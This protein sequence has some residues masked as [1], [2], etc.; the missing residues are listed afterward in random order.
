M[1]TDIAGPTATY[2]TF[3]SSGGYNIAGSQFTPL[4]DKIVVDVMSNL[5]LEIRLSS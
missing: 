4:N 2:F 5:F 1:F 3:T